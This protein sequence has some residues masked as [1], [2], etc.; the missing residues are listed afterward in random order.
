MFV[1]QILL[2]Q[3]FKLYIFCLFK[4]QNM[5]VVRQ[6]L[7][8][9]ISMT[10]SILMNGQIANQKTQALNAKNIQFTLKAVMARIIVLQVLP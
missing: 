10:L 2:I 1:S 3:K 7:Q 8:R 5:R 9:L 4:F 6:Y